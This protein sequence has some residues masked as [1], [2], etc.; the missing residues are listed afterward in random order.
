MAEPMSTVVFK[1]LISRY[2]CFID[3]G[4]QL[5]LHAVIAHQLK[6]SIGLLMMETDSE[7]RKLLKKNLHRVR[8]K[9]QLI[10]AGSV[11]ELARESKQWRKCFV[12]LSFRG[13]ETKILELLPE[14]LQKKPSILLSLNQLDA[15]GVESVAQ[16]LFN[17]LP[18]QDYCCYCLNEQSY[19][20]T[21]LK[22]ESR[23]WFGQH[24]HPKLSV[25]CVP[26]KQQKRIGTLL[27]RI[28]AEH[29]LKNRSSRQSSTVDT[30]RHEVVTAKQRNSALKRTHRQLSQRFIEIAESDYFRVWQWIA[31][32]SRLI[33]K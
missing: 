22:P 25:L 27:K 24:Y 30:I 1:Q 23:K 6:P 5:G 14:L 21:E 12:K 31:N 8:A 29:Y 20:F 11:E 26:A 16:L 17:Q 3:I 19:E 2:D 33:K 4:A 32:L 18:H 13:R 9:H 10:G 28:L 15:N 7:Q